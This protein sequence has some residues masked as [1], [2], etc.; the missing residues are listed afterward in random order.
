MCISC[1]IIVLV[2]KNI[3]VTIERMKTD[4]KGGAISKRT[5]TTKPDKMTKSL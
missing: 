3:V 2:M 4:A 5:F 1:D